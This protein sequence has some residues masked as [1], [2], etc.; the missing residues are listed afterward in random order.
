MRENRYKLIVYGKNV[1]REFVVDCNDVTS[2]KIGTN[3]NCDLRFNKDLFFEEFEFDM[4]YL[5]NIWQISCGENIYFTSDGV[6]KS[7][8]RDL[9]HGDVITAKYKS[10]N[11]ELF[12][13][14]FFLDFDSVDR[15]YNKVID[16]SKATSISV[17]GMENCDIFIDD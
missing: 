9:N 13:M 6:M 14:S 5:S 2:L 11:S 16:V 15:K 3:K 12:R 4:T 8:S 1:Y 17:G 7:L 10:S